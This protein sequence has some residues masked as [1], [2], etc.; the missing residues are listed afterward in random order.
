MIYRSSGLFAKRIGE[1]RTQ[2][3]TKLQPERAVKTV[4]GHA[5]ITGI[6]YFGRAYTTLKTTG[7][8]IQLHP[9]LKV[10]WLPQPTAEFTAIEVPASKGVGKK[11]APKTNKPT[12]KTKR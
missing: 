5:R 7:N 8:L 11:P 4:V 3:D 6:G 2:Y 10:E 9:V 12:H 1:A